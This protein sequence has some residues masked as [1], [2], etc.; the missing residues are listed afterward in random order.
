MM[1]HRK[2]PMSSDEE[3]RPARK[4]QLFSNSHSSRTVRTIRRSYSQ[5]RS[6]VRPHVHT[7][8]PRLSDVDEFLTVKTGH[9]ADGT[10]RFIEGRGVSQPVRGEGS[11]HFAIAWARPSVHGGRAHARGRAQA[12][13]RRRRR[14]ASRRFR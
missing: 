14:H 1:V 12:T 10:Q 8:P 4:P 11:P 7:T 9:T 2:N 3:F 6:H 5:R 13:G